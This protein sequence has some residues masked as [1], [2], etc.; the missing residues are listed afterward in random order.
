MLTDECREFI[1]PTATENNSKKSF[2]QNIQ[3]EL[4][5]DSLTDTSLLQVSNKVQFA[6]DL[7]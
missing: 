2:G 4:P 7:F 3:C 6:D 1:K 5:N